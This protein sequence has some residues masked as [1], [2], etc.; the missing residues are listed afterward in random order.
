MGYIIGTRV[1]VFFRNSVLTQKPRRLTQYLPLGLRGVHLPEDLL[2]LPPLYE[3]GHGD[4]GVGGGGG[5]VEGR[6]VGAALLPTLSY[7]LPY[8]LPPQH[9]FPTNH[10]LRHHRSHLLI[11]S[12]SLPKVSVTLLPVPARPIL[13]LLLVE[14]S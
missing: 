14:G 10:W 3:L 12:K 7:R 4:F 1:F 2:P 13:E 9:R 8:L 6:G 11:P 5:G